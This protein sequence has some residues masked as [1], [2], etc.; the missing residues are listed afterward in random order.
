M[1]RRIVAITFLT[2]ALAAP[3]QASASWSWSWFGG[4]YCCSSFSSYWGG[5]GGWSFSSFS[6]QYQT[7][8]WPTS[9]Q[10]YDSHERDVSVPE[11]ATMALLATGLLGMGWVARRRRED[12]RD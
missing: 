5:F 4:G 12:Q 10:T 1:I 11:P 9:Y 2:V 3:Q 6:Y 8:T 7:V